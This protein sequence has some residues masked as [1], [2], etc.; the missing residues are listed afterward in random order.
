MSEIPGGRTPAAEGRDHPGT[1]GAQPAWPGPARGR[2]RASDAERDKVIAD[3]GSHFQSGRLD[4]AEFGERL[5][6]AAGATY[7]DELDRLQSDLP[8]SAPAAPPRPQ[9][10]PGTPRQWSP[11][12]AAVLVVL[13]TM[14]LLGITTGTAMAG[15]HGQGHWWVPWWLIPI[16]VII[17]RRLLGGSGTRRGGRW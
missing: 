5:D 7:R 10:Q 17:I 4:S 1:G 6:A 11:A 15:R 8:L 9:P 14:L 3:L 16:F 12:V 13:G 2:I